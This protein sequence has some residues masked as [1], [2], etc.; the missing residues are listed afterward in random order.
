MGIVGQRLACIWWQ[1]TIPKGGILGKCWAAV[2][3]SEPEA[4]SGWEDSSGRWLSL[5]EFSQEAPFQRRDA[6]CSYPRLSHCPFWPWWS[7]FI[8]CSLKGKLGECSTSRNGKRQI[9][10]LYWPKTWT[11]FGHATQL[12]V[13][14][15][16]NNHIAP[17]SGSIRHLQNC[18]ED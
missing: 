18:C 1:K 17:C 14:L 9:C 10:H 6:S 7:C 12:A 3:H 8:A 15:G 13:D 16:A 2:Y 4:F 11:E 5:G